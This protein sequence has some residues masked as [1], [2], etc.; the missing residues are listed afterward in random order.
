MFGNNSKRIARSRKKP[1]W[2]IYV[3]KPAQ[4]AFALIMISALVFSFAAAKNIS[5]GASSKCPECGS[6][7]KEIV[8]D[9]RKCPESSTVSVFCTNPSCSHYLKSAI[10]DSL[11][12]RTEQ[13]VVHNYAYARTVSAGCT[14]DG[15]KLYV[16]SGCG[17]TQKTNVIKATG[18]KYKTTTTQPTC[19]EEGL[20]KSVCS[21]CG[22]TVSKILPATGHSYETVTAD[23]TCTKA[24]V[25]VS[26]CS[27]CNDTIA[28]DIPATG[29]SFGEWV[30]GTEPAEGVPGLEYRLCE[31]CGEREE[32]EIPA[33][34]PEK[35]PTGIRALI[36]GMSAGG[37]IC[38]LIVLAA[39]IA[40]AILK[41]RFNKN[42]S[43]GP[44]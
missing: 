40:A 35:K 1:A 21:L 2:F 19:T 34:E 41:I 29:H 36:D 6:P 33:L 5:F 13:R 38:V 43:K 32:R 12:I 17:K 10:D 11:P 28:V 14:T 30:T 39:G 9:S 42:H 31:V 3:L 24:G 23:P 25:T 18:H 4:F 26:I 16:C 27:I 20:E 22:N 8:T 7:V 44:L 37:K 15:Y